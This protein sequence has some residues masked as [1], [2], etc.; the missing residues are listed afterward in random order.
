MRLVEGPV[1]RLRLAALVGD[2]VHE[3]AVAQ[4]F[5]LFIDGRK[6][7]RSKAL[8]RVIVRRE[9]VPVVGVFSLGPGDAGPLRIRLV[10]P[11]EEDPLPRLRIVCDPKLEGLARFA[12]LR[13]MDREG[14]SMEVPL[15]F[16]AAV[17]E[18]LA[19]VQVPRVE[20]D[21][22]ETVIDR[23]E[24]MGDRAGDRPLPVIDRDLEA[25]V[26]KKER[27]VPRRVLGRIRR[28]EGLLSG[29]QKTE[30]PARFRKFAHGKPPGHP[31]RGGTVEAYLGLTRTVPVRTPKGAYGRSSYGSQRFP[32]DR[33]TA[34]TAPKSRRRSNGYAGRCDG[35]W[36]TFGGSTSRT[37]NSSATGSR[38]FDA[39]RSQDSALGSRLEVIPCPGS[40]RHRRSSAMRSWN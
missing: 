5:V 29:D 40:R 2:H 11:G 13:Q 21:L 27:P 4:R 3:A 14:F 22:G 6:D 38:A 31:A 16:V 18:D 17:V 32:D 30:S 33:W 7:F 36:K 10:R 15:Q 24:A 23:R 39:N 25:D 35:R 26:L 1:V 20:G 19:D 37:A 9:P 12:R 8:V 28:R 34:T